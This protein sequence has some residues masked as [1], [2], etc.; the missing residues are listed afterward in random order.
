MSVQRIFAVLLFTTVACSSG[1]D[2]S[3]LNYGGGQPGAALPEGGEI[4]HEN[5]RFLGQAE[6]T[7]IMVYQ[8]TGP[9]K[10]ETAPFAVPAD[11]GHGQFG[12]C[13]DERNGS[14]TW[15]VKP[16]TGAT[17]LDLPKAVELTGPGIT[18]SLNIT[19]SIPPNTIGNSTFRQYG[20]TYGGGAPNPMGTGPMGFNATLTAAEST[21]GADYTLDIGKKDENGNLSTMTYH[22]PDRFVAPLGLGGSTPVM[23]TTG[24]DLTLSWTAP[25]NDL[26]VSGKDHTKKTYFNLTFFVDDSGSMT[27]PA[28][29]ICFSDGEGHTMIP[30]AVIDA[31]K[32]RGLMVNANL[33]HWMDAREAA[34]GEMRRFDLVT[35]YSNISLY[36]KQ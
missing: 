30:A 24:T 35:I 36:M 5:V 31:L 2:V 22:M 17:F 15:P 1:T 23:I 21:P 32:P 19:K 28:Q 26:G 9:G 27:N 29:F 18:G 3:E 12:N 11:G 34:P 13:V 14:P 6:Q 8:Y 7:W 4:R 20:F 16:I 33:S 10:A 25:P